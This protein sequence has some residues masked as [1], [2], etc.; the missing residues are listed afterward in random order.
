MKKN[1]LK[2]MLR[3]PLWMDNQMKNNPTLRSMY[4]DCLITQWGAVRIPIEN[5]RSCWLVK[6]P[7]T[8]RRTFFDWLGKP[9]GSTEIHISEDRYVWLGS[10]GAITITKTPHFQKKASLNSVIEQEMKRWVW[11]KYFNIKLFGDE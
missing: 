9:T 11:N 6:T 7:T 2:V 8:V 3:S 10:K 5:D 4:E 1:S